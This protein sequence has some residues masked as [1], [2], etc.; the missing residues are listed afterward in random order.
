MKTNFYD[1]ESLENVFT[2]SNYKHE[3]NEVDIYYL[4]DTEDLE[5]KIQTDYNTFYDNLSK[6]IYEKNKNFNGKINLYNL[7]TQEANA[8]LAKTMG[9]SDSTNCNNPNIDS[10]FDTVDKDFRPICDTDPSYDPNKHPYLLG[11]NNLNYDTTMLAQYF[12]TVYSFKPQYLKESDTN[13]TVRT[14]E[15]I[16]AKSMRTFNDQLFWDDFK[17]NMSKRLMRDIDQNGQISVKDDWKDIRKYIRD[18]FINSGRHVDV[19]LLNEKQKYVGLKRLLG[20]LGYQILESDKLDSFNNTIRTL[21]ELYELIAYNVSDVVNLRELFNYPYYKSQFELK[22]GLMHKYPELIYEEKI[23][24]KIIKDKDGKEQDIEVGLYKPNISVETVKPR[25][26]TINSSSAQFAT[27]SLCPYGNLNDDKV[28]SF[29]YP[30]KAKAKEYGIERI[31]VLEKVKTFFYDNFK[32]YPHI[33]EKFDKIYKYYKSLEG[34]NFNDSKA[35]A[36]YYADETGQLPKELE[37]YN[38]YDLPKEENNLFYYYKD[39]TPSSCFVTFSIGGIHG[40]EANIAQF[41]EDYKDWQ[42][43]MQTMNE[44][45]SL[46]PDPLDAR[47]QKEITLSNGET[48]KW[49]KYIAPGFSIKKLEAMTEKERKEQA[50]RDYTKEKPVIF[51]KCTDGSTEINK[52]KYTYTSYADVNHEDFTSYYPNLLRMMQAFYN[53]RLEGG[54]DRYGDIFFEKEKFGKLRKDPS[55]SEEERAFY[56]NQREGTKL[57]L[58]SAS[59]AANAKFDNAIKMSNKII[60]MRVLGQ[61]FTYFIGQSQTLESAKIISTNTDGLYSIMEATLNNELLAKAA[62]DIHVDIEPEPMYL[63]SKDTNNRMEVMSDKNGNPIVT[64][65]AG[66]CLAC[67]EDT[68]PLY[69]LTHPAIIDWALGEYLLAA[70]QGYESSMHEPF[71][72]EL[73]MKILKSAFTKMDTQ[74]LLR[75]FQ[76]VIASS[77]GSRTYNFGVLTTNPT[78]ILPL[79]Q[80]NRTFIMKDGTQNCYF[81][82]AAT[83]KKITPATIAKRKREGDPIQQ[84]DEIAIRIL[85]ANGVAQNEIEKTHEASLKKV[86]NI[87]RDWHIF[88]ENQSLYTLDKEEVDF[89]LDNIDLDKYLSLVQDT[90]EKNWMNKVPENFISNDVTIPEAFL[91]V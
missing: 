39:G 37:P 32:T 74:H 70:S 50:Y 67:Y 79:Q 38:I 24:H 81:I 56:S 1:I 80:Y 91:D 41:E 77:N 65:S 15:P 5:N 89:I 58:N 14:F 40:Q 45:K 8:H 64:S 55:L 12:H 10:S 4:I 52:A 2:L 42:N 11:Y 7:K 31:N 20:M 86:T 44:I 48:I 26:L 87:E 57:I 27:F 33:I 69:S 6:I 19:A 73:G 13:I 16:T 43:K 3:D 78:A 34:K 83:A 30:S 29:E 46:Y 60:T 63:I 90:F 35:Y 62:Q 36:N 23:E 9:V 22:L 88:I 66:G 18:N 72:K 75:M 28:V 51:T 76:N 49:N 47:N 25:R 17:G 82:E 85:Q 21:D 61:L 71:N 84:H 59:G 68:S 53:E 54:H